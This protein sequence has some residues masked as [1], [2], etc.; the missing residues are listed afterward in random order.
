MQ[1]RG[2]FCS[3]ALLLLQAVA[4][5]LPSEYDT[6][7]TSQSLNSSGSMPV[8]GGD[9]GLN[10]WVQDN[11]LLFYIAQSGAFDENNSLLKLGRVNITMNPNPFASNRRSSFRQRL[12]IN[13]GYI[14]I[15]GG[16]GT[17]LKIWV[18]MDTSD[19]HVSSRSRVPIRYT[20]SL[21][22]WRTE[23]YQMVPPEQQQT[24]WGV[25]AVPQL[26]VPYQRPDTVGF[27]DSGV[28]SYH[29]ND[30]LPLWDAQ[31]AEQDIQDPESFFNPMRNN[32]FGLFMYSPDLK[33]TLMTSGTYINTSYTGFQLAST[34]ASSR[35][36][37]I[38]GTDQQQTTD[39]NAW[40][41][42]LIAK[43]KA[44]LSKNQASTIAW[45]NAYWDRSHIII[46]PAAGNSDPGFQVGK[47]YQYF[48][49][50]MACNAK[51][52]Y[53]TRFNGGL[54]TFDPVL[55]DPEVPFTPDWRRWSGGTFTAQN[56]RLLYWPLLKTGDLDILTQGIDFYGNT[57]PNHRKLGQ[58][59]FGL[60]VALTSEQLDN[61]GLPNI[62]EYN[63][64][65]FG[66]DSEERTDLYPPGIDFNDWLSWQQDTANEF[67]D[68]A[69]MARS[70]YGEDVSKWVSFVEY[71]LAWFDEF[72]RQRN[73]L[74]SSG[75]LIIYPASGAETYKLALNPSSTVSGL[76]RVITDLLDS[77]V[78]LVKGNTT[79][80]EQYRARVPKT[81][82]H[83]CPGATELTCISPAT[84]YS[85]AQN[86]E[87]SAMY[88]VFPWSEYGLGQ[89]TNLSFAIHTYFN[90]SQAATYRGNTG[91]RQDQIWFAR[92]GL[93]D[94][95]T[96]YI[97]D[98]L[99]DSTRYRF[100][101]F[102]GPNYDWSPD[103]NHYGSAAIGLQEMVMQT[104]ALNNT[105][106]RLLGAWPADWS[107]SFK[108]TAPQQTV[109]QGK[110]SNS[111]VENLVVTP[112]SRLQDVVYGLEKSQHPSFD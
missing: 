94:L 108:L 62:Y 87:P 81:P 97:T 16:L 69:I 37:L 59:Y 32:T 67:A 48:R 36:S 6:I 3:G 55:T 43:T 49:Y 56:Q 18:D 4:I 31:V 83:Q 25:S 11:N 29:H 60:D 5:K 35:F 101:A 93:T 96:E 73:G 7:W 63:A 2:V 24:S 86:T 88:A 15:S 84:N 50:M 112:S 98:R 14:T 110:I 103:I 78:S 28:L 40:K 21:E 79:Y 39:V 46:N 75:E 104:F 95:A 52:Q 102:K 74:N 57:S 90:D 85:F 44:G 105:Q 41:Q 111:E 1:L 76:V 38:I 80:Y 9:V 53:P 100:S 99:S 66:D 13:D 17:E 82:L 68:M 8:G 33:R 42:A 47:N 19:I 27:T 72:Y 26:P 22:S 77:D 71:Q 92:M 70:V 107:G 89:P 91:W 45:W 109:V 106:I 58:Q 61:T 20:A 34:K 10:V 12:N 65:A 51:G 23:G 30:D 64:R 54:F